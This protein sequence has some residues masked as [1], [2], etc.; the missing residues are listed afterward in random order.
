MKNRRVKLHKSKKLLSSINIIHSIC[1]IFNRTNKKWRKCIYWIRYKMQV[2]S[3]YIIQQKRKKIFFFLFLVAHNHL[4]VVI[5]HLFKYVLFFFFVIYSIFFCS[6]LV[7]IL[8]VKVQ[9]L[10]VFFVHTLNK[11]YLIHRWQKYEKKINFI[12]KNKL[13]LLLLVINLWFKWSNIEW[14]YSFK[15]SFIIFFI[16]TY[17]SSFYNDEY[18][19]IIWSL[20]MFISIIT[21]KKF[22]IIFSNNHSTWNNQSNIINMSINS[23]TPSFTNFID[24]YITYY[25]EKSYAYC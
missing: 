12:Q 20:F 22:F 11:F 18:C 2:I 15:R 9:C 21:Y 14:Y 25:I 13:F 3:L 16:I 1:F 4:L 19:N 10:F 6:S 5:M 24:I 17:F 23:N 8:N 7:V